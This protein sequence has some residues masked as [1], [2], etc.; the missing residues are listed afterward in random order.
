MKLLV[1]IAAHYSEDR[2]QYLSKVIAN[3]R[4]YQCEVDIFI[5]CDTSWPYL[6]WQ[7]QNH[8][9]PNLS[10]PF[11][12]TLMHREHF[13]RELDNYDWFAYI[14]DDI[15]IPWENFLSYTK[16][17]VQLWPTQVPSFVRVEE[18]DGELY[19]TDIKDR[20]DRK[21]I[22]KDISGKHFL[23]LYFPQNYNGFWIASQGAMRNNMRPDFTK[24]HTYREKAA[25]YLM[26]ELHK[27]G[28]LEIENGHI[29]EDCYAYHLPNNYVTD[30]SIKVKEIF[31]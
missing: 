21:N 27:P 30:K 22:I 1:C 14:E 11:H 2:I 25:S 15:L 9:H 19:L 10:H 28:L 17:F 23:Q 12:L 5:D 26:W 6:G 24:L 18:K 20:Q 8:L 13:K 29:K 16:K 31:K 4:Q 7:Y 3:L